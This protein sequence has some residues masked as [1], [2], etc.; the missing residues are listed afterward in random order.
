[1][2][3]LAFLPLLLALGCSDG[4]GPGDLSVTIATSASTLKA[5]E[6]LDVTVTVANLTTVP[7]TIIING[8]PRPFEVRDSE[9]DI[10]GP[11]SEP[12]LAYRM[13][14]RLEPGDTH[15]FS[16]QW[17]GDSRSLSGGSNPVYE[18]LPPGN[19]DLRGVVPLDAGETVVGGAAEV[20]IV[21]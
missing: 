20:S 11:G 17:N 4:M 12:C 5:G 1:M 6:N 15:T 10:V 7:R 14:R 2:R 8:C 19:Y 13:T 9:G 3:R 16:F 18:S 21:P